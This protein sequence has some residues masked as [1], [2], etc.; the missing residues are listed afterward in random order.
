M[1]NKRTLTARQEMDSIIRFTIRS[2]IIIILFFAV[3][4]GLEG[5]GGWG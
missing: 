3:L 5:C 2:F 1:K 4:F